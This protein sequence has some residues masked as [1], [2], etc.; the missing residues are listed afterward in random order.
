MS[1]HE[2]IK[3]FLYENMVIM[4]NSKWFLLQSTIYNYLTLSL[5]FSRVAQ[6]GIIGQSLCF[7]GL[8]RIY[9]ACFPSP[10]LFI[11]FSRYSSVSVSKKYQNY[12]LRFCNGNVFFLSDPWKMRLR[13]I[14]HLTR[15]N[16]SRALAYLS[17]K[18]N[19][20]DLRYEIFLYSQ[21][22]FYYCQR[23]LKQYERKIPFVFLKK[24]KKKFPTFTWNSPIT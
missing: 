2:Y 14:G 10:V 24:K 11:L 20:H 19:F 9:G 8:N 5:S 22:D 3:I 4:G 12:V 23:S 17:Y 7:A 15:S 1:P 16:P 18:R 21:S 6:I 13:S